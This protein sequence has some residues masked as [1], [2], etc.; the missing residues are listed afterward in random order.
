[1]ITD[2]SAVTRPEA[3]ATAS[4]RPQ[5]HGEPTGPTIRRHRLGLELRR[6]REAAGLRLEDAAA[7]LSVAPSTLSRIETGQA[8]AR[9]SYVR[10]LLDRYGVT[11]DAELRQL[12]DWAREGQRKGWWADYAHL[13]PVGAGTYLGLEAAASAIRTF[14]VQIVPGLLQTGD[15]AAAVSSTA[16]S[17]LSPDAAR[18]LAAVTLRRPDFLR[19]CHRVHAIIDESALLRSVGTASIMAAQLAHLR[20]WQPTMRSRCR[21]SPCLGRSVC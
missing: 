13:L 6:F 18:S 12:T 20:N 21:Y 2:A 15:Y 1:M 14:A 16:R 4:S 9:T 5:G 10:M 7:E 3:S 11:G 17:D 19:G 8:P